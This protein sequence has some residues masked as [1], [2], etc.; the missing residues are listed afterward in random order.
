M[1][2]VTE[3]DTPKFLRMSDKIKKIRARAEADADLAR[4]SATWMP[5]TPENS[6]PEEHG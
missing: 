5:S 3:G 4:E 2:I 6:R 1:G